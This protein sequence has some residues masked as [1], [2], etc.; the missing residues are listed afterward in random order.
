MSSVVTFILAGGQ[1]TR[2][3][4]LTKY[5]SKPAVPIA[6]K[7]RLID[8]PISN[9]IHSG[10]RKIFILTQ[11]AA[12]SLHRHIMTTYR[13]SIFSKDFV[14]ILAAQQT[15]E[16]RDWYQGTAD[17]VRQNLRYIEGFGDLVLIL[18]GDHLY[19]MDY[20]KFVEYH[21]EKQADI[22]ISVIP[23]PR[24]RAPQLGL[25]KPDPDGRIVAFKEKPSEEAELDEMAVSAEVMEKFGIEPDG[26]THLASM[27]IY[28]FNKQTLFE[29]LQNST[30]S[31][32]GR[33][34]IPAALETKRV[35]S[36]FFDGYWEDIGT[37]GAFFDA[38]I[39]LTRPLPRFNFYDE[40]R[41]IYS[42]PRFLPGSKILYSTVDQSILCEGSIV[43]SASIKN[44]II[45]V[46]SVIGQGCELEEAIVMGADFF[47]TPA[48]WAVHKKQ[49]LPRLG[50]G[51]NTVIRRAIVDKN[52]R[53]GNNVR[54][55]NRD[56][57]Q[58]AD[59]EKYAIRDGII[60]IPKN[61]VLE[62]GFEV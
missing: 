43:D 42:H 21:L 50:I 4:P 24:D 8:I 11:F 51:N 47:E 32:F 10:Y 15:L 60:V 58:Q 39:D 36:Y 3:Y 38:Q 46:R 16:N 45:G 44:S 35:F 54:L 27:G 41:P 23:V 1:G 37:I 7:F 52:V 53:I 56:G 40:D 26:R 48:E 17:A 20:R 31:D 28:V 30:A 22:T 59:H 62:D 25:M 61:T 14:T 19:R 9:S 18:S 29:L 34:V 6:G 49:G 12:E 55:I 57:V 13:F 5:R 2:L 33:E